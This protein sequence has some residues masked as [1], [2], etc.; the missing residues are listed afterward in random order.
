MQLITISHDLR[1]TQSSMSKPIFRKKLKR[2]ALL[3]LALSNTA[4]S[5]GIDYFDLTLEEILAT[6][7]SVAS[8]IPV[9]IGNAPATVS[10]F[11]HEDLSRLGIQELDELF[12][13]VPGFISQFNPVSGNQSYLVT[14]GHAQ[15]YANTILFLLNGQ[16]INDDYTGGISYFFRY[17]DISQVERIEII[18]GPGS[19]LYGSN[20]FNG[21]VNIITKPQNHLSLTKGNLTE[22]GV[23]LGVSQQWRNIGIGFNAVVK[24]D[25]GERYD[26]VY[27]RFGIQDS[28]LDPAKAEQAVLSLSYDNFQWR[29]LYQTSQREGYY[30]FRRLFDDITQLK[31]TNW[32]HQAQYSWPID[33]QQTI[34]FAAQHATSKRRSLG[35]LVPQFPP[36]FG[37][38]PFLFGLELAHESSS[39]SIDSDYKFND[40][41]QLTYGMS[42]TQS[43]VPNAFL[44]SNYDIFDELQYLEALTLFDGDTQRTVLDQKRKIQSAF[45]QLSSTLTEQLQLTLGLRQDN[46][47]DVKGRLNPRLSINYQID[48]HHIVKLHYGEAYRVPSLGDMYDDESGLTLGNENLDPTTLRSTELV[49]NYLDKTRFFSAVFFNNDIDDLIGFTTGDI[50]YLANI[51]KN[52]AQGIELEWKQEFN[53]TYSLQGHF[54]HLFKNRSRFM[55]TTDITPSE[56]L[57]PSQYGAISVNMKWTP[58]WS[59]NLQ[60]LWHDDIDVITAPHSGIRLNLLVNRILSHGWNLNLRVKNLLDEAHMF[61]S[62]SIIGE[63]PNGEIIQQFPDRGMEAEFSLSYQ[64]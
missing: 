12:N 46:Y 20:A 10:L 8:L 34:H 39:F 5:E 64:F 16:R 63:T 45:I 49:Y 37:Q 42:H 24:K 25:R 48:R 22:Y 33:E 58:L 26:E 44:K 55:D 43:R 6:E 51:A 30:L 14:R 41:H 47:N 2:L 15:K 56:Q 4:L 28:T 11:T 35:A 21:V 7:I 32:V 17:F 18:R 38:A 54:T 27:D 59:S 36:E 19:A 1:L 53:D 52:Q 40:H 29:S 3:L 9:T 60:V 23:K 31:L 57:A 62:S 61:G 13:F 50:S